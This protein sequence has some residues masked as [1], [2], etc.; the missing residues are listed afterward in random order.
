[1]A[2]NH[3]FVDGNKRT[4]WSATNVFY[5]VN[6]FDLVV[7]AGDVVAIMVDIAEGQLDVPTIAALLKQWTQPL[8]F[9]AE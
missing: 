5:L 6:G 7:E 1:M 4:A 3:P 2:R 9:T 8:Q